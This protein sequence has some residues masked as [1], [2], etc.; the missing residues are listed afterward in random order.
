MQQDSSRNLMVESRSVSIQD[1][2]G[3]NEMTEYSESLERL[4]GE[5]YL[6]PST[7]VLTANNSMG[8]CV[9][10]G[11]VD[12]SATVNN[13]IYNKDEMF[14]TFNMNDDSEINANYEKIFN[15][16][17]GCHKSAQQHVSTE[18]LNFS[19]KYPQM[20]IGTISSSGSSSLNSPPS[21]TV[22]N[23]SSF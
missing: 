20:H 16:F 11:T 21:T 4:K 23:M 5:K 18:R 9:A 19:D 14:E 2:L 12:S 6:D 8:N 15:D 13:D 1:N 10:G 22:M 17:H 7:G 3:N